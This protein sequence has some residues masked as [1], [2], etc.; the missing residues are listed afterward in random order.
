M[1][2]SLTP[3]GFTEKPLKNTE[4]REV[5][6]DERTPDF[7]GT[8]SR[9]SGMEHQKTDPDAGGSFG[10]GAAGTEADTDWQDSFCPGF[11]F[12]I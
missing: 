4:K 3:G 1:F 5:N 7:K 12:L 2:A 8:F 6:P 10:V 11:I 9:G